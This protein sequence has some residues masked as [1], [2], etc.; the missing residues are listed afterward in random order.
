MKYRADAIARTETMQA[1]NRAERA[2]I[3]QNIEEGLITAD[4]V[5]KWWSDTGDERTRISH[6][7]LGNRYKKENAI[8]F[9][10]PFET[11]NGSK[12]LYPGDTSL[13]ADLH[14]IIHCRCKCQYYI[15]FAKRWM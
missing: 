3:A 4:M 8:G 6:V 5:T 11:M 1:I 14:E 13:G 9:D 10:E 7:N 15:E 2:A 12:L